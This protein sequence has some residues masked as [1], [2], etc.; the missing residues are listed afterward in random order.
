MTSTAVKVAKSGICG[1]CSVFLLVLGLIQLLP[2]II[3]LV[4][5]DYWEDDVFDDFHR[6]KITLKP[7]TLKDIELDYQLKLLYSLQIF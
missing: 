1:C 2:G 4:T 7:L 3:L 6:Y 5:F